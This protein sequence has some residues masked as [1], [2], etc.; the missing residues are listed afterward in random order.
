MYFIGRAGRFGTQWENGFV[1]TYKSKDLETLKQCLSQK[2]E[3]ITKAGLSPTFDQIQFYTNN[4]P[5][6]SLSGV[7]VCIFT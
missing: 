6:S 5:E 3:P 1:T 2:A 4:L 7:V